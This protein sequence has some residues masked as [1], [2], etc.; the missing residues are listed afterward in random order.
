MAEAIVISSIVVAS[1]ALVGVVGKLLHT[2]RDNIK[3]C[4]GITFRSRSNSPNS[5]PQDQVNMNAISNDAII[6]NENIARE[7]FQSI[8]GEFVFPNTRI[9]SVEC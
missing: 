6:H 5:Q 1:T 7:R 2:F 3:S 9:R 8:H 4:W